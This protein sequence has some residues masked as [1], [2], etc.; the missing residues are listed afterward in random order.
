MKAFIDKNAELV[1]DPKI[2]EVAEGVFAKI[3]HVDLIV[4]LKN[5]ICIIEVQVY[6]FIDY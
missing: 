6:I 3:V 4:R 2:E 5:K 1:E